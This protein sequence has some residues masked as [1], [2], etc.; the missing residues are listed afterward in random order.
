MSHFIVECLSAVVLTSQKQTQTHLYSEGGG[1]RV[2]PTGGHIKAP[3]IKSYHTTK[4]EL[5]VRLADGRELPIGFSFDN[6]SVRPG[7]AIT[8]VVVYRTDTQAGYYARLF[9]QDTQL[10]YNTLSRPDWRAL[11]NNHAAKQLDAGSDSKPTSFGGLYQ[12]L[13]A[14]FQHTKAE[15]VKG[16]HLAGD[17]NRALTPAELNSPIAFELEQAIVAA[18]QAIGITLN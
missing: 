3:Q 9:N 15:M 16:W 14:A 18:L 2:G 5:F 12:R 8:L 17:P 10:I 11:V 13:R 4:H 7:N 1:G 6:I